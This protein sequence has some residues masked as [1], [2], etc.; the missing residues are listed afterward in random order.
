MSGKVGNSY[1]DL[2]VK[3]C[4][5]E[6]LNKELLLQQQEATL[7]FSWSG[8]LGHWYWN[9]E[10]DSVV[11]HPLKVTTLGYSTEKLP[12]QVSFQFFTDKL[13]PDDYEKTMQAMR[14]HLQGKSPVYEIEY[15]ILA[16]DGSWKWFYDRGKVTQR[17]EDGRPIFLAGIVFDITK[18]KERERGLV[19]QNS[20]LLREVGT[21]P[22]TNIPNRR[23]VLG[24]LQRKMQL[25]DMQKTSLTVGMFDIDH[26]KR[27]NDSKGHVY[28]DSV[29]KKIADLLHTKLRGMDTVGRYGGEE[30]MVVFF[31]AH[32]EGAFAVAERIRR[33]IEQL[34]FGDGVK[35]TLSGGLQEYAFQEIV[36]LIDQADKNLYKAKEQGRNR[37]VV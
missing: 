24:E 2:Q 34:D 10:T 13:H 32:Q 23:A 17:G 21:D 12:D 22:L 29:L 4:E 31:G 8:N 3:I 33:Q 25:A 16:K 7:D 30:F 19:E 18:A 37:I 9:V 14:D 28:G 11:F 35:V 6:L 36:E 26:F 20:A 1:E 5:L 15:R 27:I